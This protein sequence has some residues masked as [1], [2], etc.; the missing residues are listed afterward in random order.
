MWPVWLQDTWEVAP[1][2]PRQ[3]PHG[4]VSLLHVREAVRRQGEARGPRGLSECSKRPDVFK[5]VGAKYWHYQKKHMNK[6]VRNKVGFFSIDSSFFQQTEAVKKS[7]KVHRC[8]SV[9]GSNFARHKLS[10]QKPKKEKKIGVY[11]CVKGCHYYT[12]NTYNFNRHL[13]SCRR[14]IITIIFVILLFLLSSGTCPSTSQRLL[15]SWEVKS[16]I[17]RIRRF[18][19]TR[20]KTRPLITRNH[21][22]NVANRV[23]I[24]SKKMKTVLHAIR[25]VIEED[26][27]D[28]YCVS[29]NY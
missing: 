1:P 10:N 23:A 8:R 12:R 22:F 13:E 3:G 5:T 19:A 14:F 18:K 4:E 24:S 16:I 26:M 11:K 6:T 20:P 15:P 29:W 9:K 21:D 28:K 7:P 27:F 17:P 2:R 25:D